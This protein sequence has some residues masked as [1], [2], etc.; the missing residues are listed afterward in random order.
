M[1]C[2]YVLLEQSNDLI[3]TCLK[4]TKLHQP[5]ESLKLRQNWVQICGF[6]DLKKKTNTL[7]SSR[8][9]VLFPWRKKNVSKNSSVK[10]THVLTLHLHA[11]LYHFVLFP[12][13]WARAVSIQESF[14]GA[15]RARTD[16]YIEVFH[17]VGL[18]PN[19]HLEKVELCLHFEHLWRLDRPMGVLKSCYLVGFKIN[20]YVDATWNL[21][22]QKPHFWTK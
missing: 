9:L 11:L 8:N 2:V 21:R 3:S 4:R 10:F 15:P 7:P 5:L 17:F 12:S 13:A 19:C 1:C 20:G 18:V 22:T 14:R 16:D 6:G